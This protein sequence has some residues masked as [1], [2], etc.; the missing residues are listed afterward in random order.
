L[1]VKERVLKKDLRH[2]TTYQAGAMQ[3]S[4]HRSLQKLSDRILEPFQIT[5]MQ[6]LIIGH[7][8]DAGTKGVR[9]SDL[10]AALSTTLPYV[11][12]AVNV[13]EARGYLQRNANSTD[14]RSKLLVL[15]PEFVPRC[16]EIEAALRQGLRDTIY[17]H[18]DP[19][20]FAIYM[21]VLY[22]LEESAAQAKN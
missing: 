21:K 4:V 18:V 13:L 19:K 15:N 16:K 6:W 10:A 8:L 5:K 12:N 7:V 14:S 9:V 20:D 22:Q 2:T 11:T 17:A 1:S 3:A